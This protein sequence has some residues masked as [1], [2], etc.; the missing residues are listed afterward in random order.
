MLSTSRSP[1]ELRRKT[2]ITEPFHSHTKVL[3]PKKLKGHTLRREVRSS[4]VMEQH[5]AH[6]NPKWWWWLPLLLLND[7]TM[8]NEISL[9]FWFQAVLMCL[10]I[11]PPVRKSES[12]PQAVPG[13][14]CPEAVA[15]KRAV[16]AVFLWQAHDVQSS[17]F[18]SR[19]QWKGRMRKLPPTL[20]MNPEP[21]P[22]S[23]GW[24]TVFSS[25]AH[26]RPWG[27]WTSHSS[28]KGT[29]YP[30]MNTMPGRNGTL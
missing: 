29:V 22:L 27:W 30:V 10:R 11:A 20:A 21:H 4:K 9:W 25:A 12:F 6:L 14:P 1:S 18:G 23:R 16:E 17:T 28:L 26:Y 19:T 7:Q 8:T 13:R 5:K 3:V 15:E 2:S 24:P